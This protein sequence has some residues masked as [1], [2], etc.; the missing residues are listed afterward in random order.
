MEPNQN[1]MNYSDIRYQARQNLHGNWTWAALLSLVWAFVMGFGAFFVWILQDYEVW[2][3]SI[4]GVYEMFLVLTAGLW[5]AGKIAYHRHVYRREESHVMD[6]FSG[7]SMKNRFWIWLAGISVEAY[8][9]LW[10]CLLVVPG[11]VK[12]Y[13][14]ALT[15]YL[16]QDSRQLT[17]QQ[18]IHM[19]E[20]LMKGHKWN[21]FVLDLTF[22]GWDIL[23]LLSGGIGLLWVEAYHDQA[24]YVFYRKIKD[25][26]Y[27]M[28]PEK[29]QNL[30]RQN[31]GPKTDKKSYSVP[32][33]VVEV[34]SD[35]SEK[36]SKDNGSEEK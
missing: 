17:S 26:E 15:Q 1:K 18:A 3:K 28:I 21:L 34:N 6:M 30:N 16:L 2:Q 20:N 32:E 13:S 31:D 25:S 7:F 22:I 12:S 4:Y 27:Y 24:R 36:Q 8:T 5:A 14:Y 33:D 9:L 29:W 11:I 35:G 19:S 23:G 10:S